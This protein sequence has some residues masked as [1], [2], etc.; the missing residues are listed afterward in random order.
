MC[1]AV[2]SNDADVVAVNN[3]SCLIELNCYD[4][5]SMCSMCIIATTFSSFDFLCYVSFLIRLD[6]VML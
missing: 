6:D 3:V 5:C 4:Y 1:V 2:D